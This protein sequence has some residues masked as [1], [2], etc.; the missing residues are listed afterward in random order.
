MH[1]ETKNAWNSL[2][3]AKLIISLAMPAAVAYFGWVANSKL[4]DLQ[5]QIRLSEKIIDK[6]I[7]IYESIRIRLNN[8]YTYIEEV[9]SYKQFTPDTIMEDRRYLHAEMH[10]QRAYW[11]PAT[12]SAYLTY[13]DEIA[14]EPWQGINTDARIRDAPGQKKTLGS[15]KEGWSDDFTGKQHP[16]HAATY[17]RL[18]N[19][20]SL[21][22]GAN[23]GSR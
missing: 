7:E 12:F 14:F 8:I 23:V 22:I 11:S 4:Q 9:G 5:H 1:Q 13:M 2:E 20:I 16:D 19:H 3:I 17:S 18:I 6:R 10:T 15:W 21:D